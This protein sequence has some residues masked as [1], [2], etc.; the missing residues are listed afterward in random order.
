MSRIPPEESDWLDLLATQ[1]HHKRDEGRYLFTS[2]HIADLVAF[3][4]SRKDG[5]LALQPVC[6]LSPFVQIWP[7][8]NAILRLAE[9]PLPR[10]IPWQ[11]V[12][13]SSQVPFRS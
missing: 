12:S 13:S 7:Q 6:E 2:R 1:H 11:K 10:R 5:D 9:I 4:V 3:S 8:A